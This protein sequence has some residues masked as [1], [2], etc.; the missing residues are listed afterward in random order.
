MW[1]KV[2]SD[3]KKVGKMFSREEEVDWWNLDQISIIVLNL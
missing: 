3:G 2:S 1:N